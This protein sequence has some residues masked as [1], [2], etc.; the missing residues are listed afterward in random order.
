[1]QVTRRLHEGWTG[2]DDSLYSIHTLGLY[3]VISV[4]SKGITLIWDK[5]TRITVELAGS[6]KVSE[7]DFKTKPFIYISLMLLIRQN[8]KM[9]GGTSS[10]D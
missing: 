6:W 5:H 2:Q 10:K 4:P 9:G 3:I 1:M 7:E 8:N